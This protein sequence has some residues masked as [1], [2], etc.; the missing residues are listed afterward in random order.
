M[1]GYFRR[2]HY[3]AWAVL[4]AGFPTALAAQ[5][6]NGAGPSPPPVQTEAQQ[7]TPRKSRF[8]PSYPVYSAVEGQPINPSPPEKSD[9]KPLFPE[10]TR[11]P[12]HKTAPYKVTTL[13]ASL[14]AP[15]ALAFLPAE[16]SSSPKNCP[17]RCA[18]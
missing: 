9:D 14:H 11:A 18:S 7:T 16:T 13:T 5:T 2:R 15:W 8:A 6:P 17:A 12:Y 1:L 4:L 10:Q 3:V